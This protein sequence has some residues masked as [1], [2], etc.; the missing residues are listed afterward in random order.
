M[1]ES[2]VMSNGA[3]RPSV[4]RIVH[5]YHPEHGGPIAATVTRVHED[6]TVDLFAMAPSENDDYLRVRRVPQE[7]EGHGVRWT[8]MPRV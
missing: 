5:L 7:G 1:S 6:G 4:G 3:A 8:W 2:A